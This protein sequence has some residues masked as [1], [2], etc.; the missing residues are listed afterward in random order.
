MSEYQ[1]RYKWRPTGF[2]KAQDFCC[3]V[4]ER[5]VGRIY[6][7]NEM[8][9][10]GWYWSMYAHG[11]DMNRQGRITSGYTSTPREAARHVEEA[12]DFAKPGQ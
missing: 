1:P 12:W 6:L 9:D 2:G 10:T 11:S 3:V 7:A 4:G 5:E 8:S